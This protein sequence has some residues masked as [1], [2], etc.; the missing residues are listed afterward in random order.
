MRSFFRALEARRVAY[1][2]I[3]GQACVMYGAATFSE[4]FDI[5]VR[6]S[7]RDLGRLVLALQDVRATI[8]KLTPPLRL[9]L[10]RRGHAL[11]F[12]IPTGRSGPVFLDVMLRPPRVRGF[13][14][15]LRRSTRLPTPW[16]DVPVVSMED[17]VEIK[18]T[19]RPADYQAITT[20]ARL[21]LEKA[22][23]SR[24]P[25]RELRRVAR[26]A[27]ENTFD[28]D[29]L[30]LLFAQVPADAASLARNSRRASIRTL[31]R[32]W[33]GENAEIPAPIE[34]RVERQ[35]A[36]ET[37]ALQTADRRYWRPIVHELRELRRR[38][39]LLREGEAVRA[40]SARA[41]AG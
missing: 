40:T 6:P 14:A 24:A 20:L 25:R 29:A 21:R 31:A 15:A 33:R 19:R 10:L 23:A 17:L 27:L 34:D 39:E 3:S 35:M 30:R 37:L 36:E 26:W 13:A 4:D 18:K 7:A 1:L 11:H 38:G 9:D 32:A 16:G 12:A 41:R 28:V 2:L 8:Y 22:I 5:W